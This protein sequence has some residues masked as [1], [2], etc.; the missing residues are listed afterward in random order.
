MRNSAVSKVSLP[1]KPD[2]N[3]DR[4]MGRLRKLESL[5]QE[6]S[7]Q[8][9]Q[10]RSTTADTS[11]GPSE[12]GSPSSLSPHLDA[13]AQGSTL[14]METSHVSK[15]FGRL[16]VQNPDQSRYISS[17]FWSRINDEVR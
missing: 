6:L 11:S 13:E 9:E 16:V 17:G 4:V 8:L 2:P 12:V 10:A 14:F 7:G 5:V 1:Q 3:V 15:E